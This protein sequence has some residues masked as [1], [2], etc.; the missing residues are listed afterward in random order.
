MWCKFLTLL[1]NFVYFLSDDCVSLFLGINQWSAMMRKMGCATVLWRASQMCIKLLGWHPFQQFQV[2]S[3]TVSTVVLTFIFVV[4]FYFH[5]YFT[6][7]IVST[8]LWVSAFF[9]YWLHTFFSGLYINWF[10]FGS[11]FSFHLFNQTYIVWLNKQWATSLQISVYC[12]FLVRFC[13]GHTLWP[14]GA[15]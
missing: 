14:N 7:L 2:F 15:K 6:V 11:L 13:D 5:L 12:E 1:C 9:K 10:M 3:P 8:I 4:D